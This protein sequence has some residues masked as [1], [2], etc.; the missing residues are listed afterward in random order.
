MSILEAL[1]F[2]IIFMGLILPLLVQFVETDHEIT[3]EEEERKAHARYR[4]EVNYWKDA[5][6]RSR[7]SIKVMDGEEFYIENRR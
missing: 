7:T 6:L 3:Q 2:T 5:A 4:R 1:C